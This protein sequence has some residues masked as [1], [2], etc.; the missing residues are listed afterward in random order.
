MNDC[1][2]GRWLMGICLAASLLGA[3]PEARAQQATVQQPAFENFSIST[4]VSA[5]DRGRMTIGGV[6]RGASSRA[7]NGPLRTDSIFGRESVG[8][9]VSVQATIHDFAERDR[10]ALAAAEGGGVPRSAMRP[11]LP[12]RAEHAFRT[13]V[14]RNGRG[15]P[16]TNHRT[17]QRGEKSPPAAPSASAAHSADELYR[18]GIRAE[19]EGRRGV[20]LVFLRQARLRG[21]PR[22]EEKLAELAGLSRPSGSTP[23]SED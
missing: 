8:S 9:R 20:A 16:E 19:A 21:C 15:E 18:R 3:G 7:V 13:L 17:V 22:S 4:T 11:R 10:Q 23:S 1:L 2:K 5:P 14:E 6:G 12:P